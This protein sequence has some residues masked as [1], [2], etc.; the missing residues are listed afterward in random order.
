MRTP[1]RLAIRPAI[2]ALAF[3]ALAG[4][5]D[6][7]PPTDAEA[8]R[9]AAYPA[10]I[11]AHRITGRVPPPAPG[12][13]AASDLIPRAERL[14]ARAARLGGPVIDAETRDRMQT[15]IAR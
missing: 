8:H 4:C 14:R 1:A 2:A 15:G 12:A 6:L 13:D 10:L 11:P 5:T 3:A 7:P 9:D